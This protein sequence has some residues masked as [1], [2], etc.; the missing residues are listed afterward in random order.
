M[1]KKCL[2]MKEIFKISEILYD[3]ME[4]EQEETDVN[5]AQTNYR[6]YIYLLKCCVVFSFYSLGNFCWWIEIDILRVNPHIIGLQ[7]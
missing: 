5:G 7:R 2:N 4:T 3:A 1:S 6:R